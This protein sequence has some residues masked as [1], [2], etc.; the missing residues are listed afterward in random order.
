MYKSTD[1][2]PFTLGAII[3]EFLRVARFS[4]K[5]IATYT[6]DT[7]LFHDLNLFGDTAEDVFEILHE[8]FN[9]ELTGFTFDEYFPVEFSEDVACMDNLEILLFFRLNF[10]LKNVCKNLTR[11][12]DEIH[13][14]YKPITLYMVEESI[15]KRRWVD[16]I[17]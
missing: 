8:T 10:I 15:K 14:K 16:F 7:R 9:V 6:Y 2:H 4:E 5:E 3:L 17:G 11:K 13:D 12:V 1:S